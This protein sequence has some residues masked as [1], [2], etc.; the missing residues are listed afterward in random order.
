MQQSKQQD[1]QG[2]AGQRPQG[3][4][5]RAQTDFETDARPMQKGKQQDALDSE[6]SYLGSTL[7]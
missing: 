6:K 3:A 4:A 7:V 2:R 5:P 1:M